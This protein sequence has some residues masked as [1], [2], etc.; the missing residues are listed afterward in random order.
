MVLKPWYDP[1]DIILGPIERNPYKVQ[2]PSLDLFHYA[3]RQVQGF[4][5]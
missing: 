1:I 5:N 3:L 2:L 4:G